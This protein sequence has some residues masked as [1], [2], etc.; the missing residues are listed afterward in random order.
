MT[1]NLPG[2]V[3]LASIAFAILL[4]TGCVVGDGDVLTDEP[5]HEQVCRAFPNQPE[6]CRQPWRGQIIQSCD[7]G[8]YTTS[9]HYDRPEIVDSLRRNV[10]V[11]GNQ[12]FFD[13]FRTWRDTFR[14]TGVVCD[15]G[16]C[17]NF[18]VAFRSHSSF[19]IRDGVGTLEFHEADST[20]DDGT[21][22]AAD[23]LW[24]AADQGEI[25]LDTTILKSCP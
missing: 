11:L 24:R 17:R 1:K 16:L 23:Y 7:E 3:L 22:E 14:D 6:R 21:G 19:P 15:S 5:P 18:V 25:Q 20:Y 12:T 10:V 13:I 2:S 8:G 9:L 4:V